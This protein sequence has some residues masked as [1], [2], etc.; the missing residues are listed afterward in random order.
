MQ[1]AEEEAEQGSGE[2]LH[3]DGDQAEALP[4]TDEMQDKM[5]D[6]QKAQ[7]DAGEQSDEQ[8]ENEEGE[9]LLADSD[10]EVNQ[11]HVVSKVEKV[12]SFSF[13]E[14]YEK[15]D[16]LGLCS[17]PRHV[18]GCSL[19]YHGKERR[20][21]EIVWVKT[22]QLQRIIRTGRTGHWI[23]HAKEHCLVGIKGNP[24]L[25]RN[26]DCDVIVSEVR[27]TSRKPDEIYNLIERMFPNCPK[28]ELFGRPHNVH[29]NWI[30]CGNQLDGVRLVDDEIVKR[31]NQE[32]PS[33]PT[34]PFRRA[35]DELV[36]YGGG[37]DAPWVPPSEAP[38]PSTSEAWVPPQAGWPPPW[39]WPRTLG[40]GPAWTRLDRRVTRHG[41]RRGDARSA[42]A[43]VSRLSR[44]VAPWAPF[45]AYSAFASPKSDSMTVLASRLGGLF[46][47]FVPWRC[48]ENVSKVCGAS[49]RLV[50]KNA[51][52]TEPLWVAHIA[53]SGVGPDVQN[54][55][56]A[57]G[58]SFTFQTPDN[59]Q[60]TRYW[61]KMRC[62]SQGNQCQ[63][64][65][66]GGPQQLCDEKVGCAPPVDTKFEATFGQKALQCNPQQE[67]Y[68]GCDYIDVS[69]VDGW[70]LPFK[71]E[72]VG[73]CSSSSGSMQHFSV[74]C[75]KLS[76]QNCP[77][78]ESVPGVGNLDLHL[79]HPTTGQISGCYSPCSK[80][81]LRNWNNTLAMSHIPRDLLVV[82]P[83]GW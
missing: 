70:T 14:A 59:L 15:L 1:K 16:K 40:S 73:N 66:S 4:V 36:A 75:S 74:D 68:T 55:K 41:G 28:L 31:Y 9:Y 52:E 77:S 3:D 46:A 48:C 69:M 13:R 49:Q 8:S 10:E 2:V 53:G 38:P 35:K 80:L 18:Q 60:A 83:P 65:G 25:N 63:L 71:F 39:G 58:Q 47:F 12:K 78:A 30:T 51:C 7:Q 34:T 17:L 81:T 62:N 11:F 32:F 43:K 29:E 82:R 37:E 21:E 27:E 19:S 54:L 5:L 42:G 79:K 57:A 6:M 22:N 61:P 44:H 26:L 50:I 33:N 76:V 45:L 56:I 24:K 20:I 23:N 72:V 67:E 64:G